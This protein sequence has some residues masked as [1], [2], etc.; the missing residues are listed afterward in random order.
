MK[1]SIT[2]RLASFAAALLIT[3][4]TFQ[5]IASYGLPQAADTVMAS[6]CLCR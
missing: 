5:L 3:F 1:T 6:A 4:A 2:T